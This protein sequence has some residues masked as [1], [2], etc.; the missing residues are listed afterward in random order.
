MQKAQIVQDTC[1]LATQLWAS[2]GHCLGVVEIK[3]SCWRWKNIVENEGTHSSSEEGTG[4]TGF[5]YNHI[6]D[7]TDNITVEEI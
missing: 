3:I 4:C 5:P 6:R 2:N 7:L 1:G